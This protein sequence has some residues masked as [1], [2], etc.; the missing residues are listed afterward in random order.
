MLERHYVSR[1]T[2]T[3]VAQHMGLLKIHHLDAEG[4]HIDS[5]QTD[6]KS[7]QKEADFFFIIISV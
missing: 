2:S 5:D 6:I 1:Q 4:M 7:Q 3:S